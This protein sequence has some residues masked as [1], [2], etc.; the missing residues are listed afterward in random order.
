MDALDLLWQLQKHDDNLQGIRE[1][2]EELEQ[3]GA[4]NKIATTMKKT[5][6]KLTDLKF[7]LKDAEKKLNKN[8]STLKDLDFKLDETEKELYEG[9]ISDLRQ[10]GYLDKEREVLRQQIDE[11]EIEIL[12]QME[13]MEEL[14]KEFIEIEKDFE[15][16]KIEYRRLIE[17]YKELIEQF[18]QKAKKE[19]EEKEKILTQIGEKI[20]NKYAQLK[21]IKGNAIVQIIDYKCSGCN[22]VLPTIVVDRL[23]FNSEIVHCENCGR[24][25]YYNR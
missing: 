19:A 14:K 20:F 18:K 8:N 2:L 9:N 21:K 23:K 4:I 22:V 7:R 6:L 16:L 3:G 10:L 5:E 17:Q 15:T 24:I 12:S 25:L 11:K 13:E 1:R